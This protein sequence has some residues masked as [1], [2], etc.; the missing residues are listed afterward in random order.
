[1]THSNPI[2]IRVGACM[3]SKGK[4]FFGIF[5]YAAMRFLCVRDARV[6]PYVTP[7]CMC[8]SIAFY[9]L[10]GG[11]KSVQQFPIKID[12]YRRIQ[13]ELRADFLCIEELRSLAVQCIS[14]RLPTRN[15]SSQR[16]QTDR[17]LCRKKIFWY[18]VTKTCPQNWFSGSN[19]CCHHLL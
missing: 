2:H 15:I 19:K 9:V 6:R 5:P 16:D 18:K 10:F 14:F 13:S 3:R 12:L 11:R 1:M 7:V 17:S 8:F 4:Y